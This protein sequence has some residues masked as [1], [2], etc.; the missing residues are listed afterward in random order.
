MRTL[1]VS[2]ESYVRHDVRNNSTCCVADEA[3]LRAVSVCTLISLIKFW[4]YTVGHKNVPYCLFSTT[5]LVFLERFYAVRRF[6][7]W[8]PVNSYSQTGHTS[9]DLCCGDALYAVLKF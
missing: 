8:V 4:L 2:T 1:F 6:P 5:T 7:T 3:L 9:Q